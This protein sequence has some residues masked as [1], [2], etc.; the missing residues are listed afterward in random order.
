MHVP[1]LWAVIARTRRSSRDLPRT[2]LP[3]P[4]RAFCP[5]PSTRRML[6]SDFVLFRHASYYASRLFDFLSMSARCITRPEPISSPFP[7]SPRSSLFLPLIFRWNRERDAGTGISHGPRRGFLRINCSG[8]GRLW[9]WESWTF[10]LKFIYHLFN[11]N[12]ASGN[13]PFIFFLLKKMNAKNTFKTFTNR[14]ITFVLCFSITHFSNERNNITAKKFHLKESIFE[15]SST[16]LNH[17]EAELNSI[18][19]FNFR[20]FYNL[21]DHRKHRN[22]FLFHLL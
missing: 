4:L 11:N 9:N 20:R 6:W 10:I 1:F 16:K 2:C 17:Y 7:P 8:V 14:I 15:I 19:E 13:V 5:L 21:K 22:F 12:D 18:L 3:L